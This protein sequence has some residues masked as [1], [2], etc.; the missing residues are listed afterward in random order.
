MVSGMPVSSTVSFTDVTSGSLPLGT[1]L[2]APVDGCGGL[3]TTASVVWPDLAAGLHR[4]RV[5]VDS[6]NAIS[7]TDEAN[8]WRD[9]EILV[10]QYA[11]Y[12]PTI[13]R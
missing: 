8:N 11:V 12:L 6:A 7:E 5:Q 9:F 10:G 3:Q 13:A 4:L 1:A 2:V